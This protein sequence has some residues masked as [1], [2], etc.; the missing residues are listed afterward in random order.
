MPLG[1]RRVEA[2]T[3]SITQHKQSFAKITE[4]VPDG[5]EAGPEGSD[6]EEGTNEGAQLD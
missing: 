6:L 4:D 1:W 3:A 2:P 5:T